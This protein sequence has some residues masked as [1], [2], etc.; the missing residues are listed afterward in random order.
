MTSHFWLC[1]WNRSET[2]GKTIKPPLQWGHVFSD[3]ETRTLGRVR[4]HLAGFN[5][6]TSFQTWKQI[7]RP[8][9][10]QLYTGF[11]GATSFQTWKR[12]LPFALTP[13][14][15]ASMGPRLFRRGNENIP[16][17]GRTGPWLQWGHVFSDVETHG[18]FDRLR[19]ACG[20]SMGPR[21]FRRGN[22]WQLGIGMKP[23]GSFNGATSFQ[24][25]KPV[26]C[27][28]GRPRVDGLQWGHVFSDVETISIYTSERADRLASMGPR[29]FRRGNAQEHGATRLG[30]RASM[31]PRLFRR[32]NCP[33][34]GNNGFRRDASMGPR[35]FRR[36]NA[37]HRKCRW[38]Q[39]KLQW[40]HVFS[41]VETAADSGRL[42]FPLRLQWG[43]V[44]SDVETISGVI[45]ST[46]RK[47]FNGATSFQTWK[48]INRALSQSHI[49][50]LQW[51]HVFSDVETNCRLI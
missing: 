20:A 44:F 39:K 35:L 5:G 48:P 23:I 11:N 13:G 49:G 19:G 27:R 6:A 31:G 37:C 51:G 22:N 34:G 4:D 43:H 28:R 12:V 16:L 45:S 24:T 38:N 30:L 14:P 32:G 29:F 8:T 3:V 41:D 2:S 26:G 21:L 47:S 50:M 18:T 36:G 33:L 15:D 9:A 40:G 46:P 7:T 10:Y 17:K 25:W 1:E 42:R